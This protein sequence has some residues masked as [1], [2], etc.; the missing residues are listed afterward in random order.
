[1]WK[2]EKWW[3]YGLYLYFIFKF[4]ITLQTEHTGTG[5]TYLNQ[6]SLVRHGPQ[7]SWTTEPRKR[8]GLWQGRSA[9]WGTGHSA[10]SPECVYMG[11]RMNSMVGSSGPSGAPWPQNLGNSGLHPYTLDTSSRAGESLRQQLG[12][13]ASLA[14]WQHNQVREGPTLVWQIPR[15]LDQQGPTCIRISPPSTNV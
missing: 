3:L 2:K 4:Q 10:G 8:E 5:Y 14:Q 1:M 11:R 13:H 7:C 6:D 12:Q 9:I 15:V